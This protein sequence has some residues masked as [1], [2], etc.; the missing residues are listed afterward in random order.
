MINTLK[1]LLLMTVLFNAS[2]NGQELFKLMPENPTEWNTLVPDKLYSPD[3]LYQY[4]NGGAELYLSYNMKEV[5]SRI[6]EKDDN[7]IRIEI[8][9]MKEARNAFGVFS[10]TRTSNEHKYGQGSQYFTGSLI[11]W[12]GNYFITLTANDENEDILKAIHE[13]AT[14]IDSQI[15]ATGELPGI[16]ELMPK[17][18][19][20]QDGFMYFHHYIWL[21]SYYYL[22]NENLLNIDESTPALL[23]KYGDKENRS[24]LLIIEYPKENKAKK[25]NEILI[26]E[27]FNNKENPCKMEDGSCSGSRVVDNYLIAVF[28]A[29]DC[30]LTSIY[31]DDF[32]TGL[33]D[34][35]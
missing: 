24:Y 13:I 5:A 30:E 12:K 11:F 16:L 4:I 20:V 27:L 8:F 3:D 33:S 7:E 14:Q 34:N 21:N 15:N 1:I 6:I 17:T 29:K 22:F 2:A 32:E 10:H 25:A 26:Q 9:D 28:N 19:L 35:H 18:G 23:A 31:L